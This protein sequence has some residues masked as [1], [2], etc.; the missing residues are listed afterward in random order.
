MDNNKKADLFAY[1]AFMLTGLILGSYFMLSLIRYWYPEA[2]LYVQIVV[3][4]ASCIVIGEVMYHRNKNM[5]YKIISYKG[6][7]EK[8]K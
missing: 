3:T 2:P 8:N 5:I 4:F 6:N 1:S 7:D